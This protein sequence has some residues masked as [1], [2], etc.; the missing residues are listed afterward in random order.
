MGGEVSY[1][2]GTLVEAIERSRLT[3]VD[4]VSCDGAGLS[5]AGLSL[6]P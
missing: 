6:G 5:L 2:R 4:A 1:G 3:P